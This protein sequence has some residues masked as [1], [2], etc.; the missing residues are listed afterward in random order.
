MQV[1][2]CDICGRSVPGILNARGKD[3]PIISYSDMAKIS[4]DWTHYDFCPDC[5]KDIFKLVHNYID[6]H[7][8]QHLTR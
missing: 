6:A 7:K 1:T 4:N 2:H 3:Y 5:A 8:V